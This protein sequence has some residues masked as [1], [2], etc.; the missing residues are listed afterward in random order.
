MI[1]H[2]IFLILISS[3]LTLSANVN[4]LPINID[5]N[6]STE[7]IESNFT[8]VGSA[9]FTVLFWDIY[10]STLYSDSGVFID[11]DTKQTL[12]FKIDYLKDITRDDLIE[13]TVEQW[14]HLEVQES[15]YLHFIPEL[16]D[17]WPNISAGDSLTLLIQNQNSRF[18]FNGDYIGSITQSSFGPLFLSI[19]L[20]PQT[21]QK[22]LR[23]KL[24][25]ELRP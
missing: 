6:L 15:E 16:I 19:W 13:R 17:I 18:Y 21:S 22:R 12:V 4:Q 5:E 23:R 2:I 8:K 10:N 20:S 3:S 9:L 24:L 11:G 14:Q 7:T 1:K 25:G